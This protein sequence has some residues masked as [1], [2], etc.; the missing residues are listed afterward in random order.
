MIFASSPAP[1][2]PPADDLISKLSEVDYQKHLRNFIN[3]VI[4]CVACVAA[5]VS[6]VVQRSARWYRNG[7]EIRLRKAYQTGVKCV[8]D[9]YLWVR[10]ILYPEVL[11]FIEEV[12][13]TYRAWQDLMTV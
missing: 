8:Q 2:F 9:C 12:K 13:Q 7:G 11:N 1:S 5:V 6:A 4:I 10:C 3:V